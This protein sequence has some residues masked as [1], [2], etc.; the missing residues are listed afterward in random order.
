MTKWRKWRCG[1]ALAGLAL[2][3]QLATT[4]PAWPA[5]Q[6]VKIG[7][8]LSLSGPGADIGQNMLR[9][10]DLYMKLHMQDLP[11]G[12]SLQIIKRD[13]GSNAATTKRLAQELI[14]RDHVQMLAGITLSPEAFTLAP[15]ATEAKIPV[16]LMNA[17]TGS[18]T[19]SSPYIVRFSHSN[20]QMAYI[21]GI[22]A[23]TH[24][25]KNAY[26]LVA[27]Y[28]AGLDNEAAFRRGFTDN[29]GKIV[30]SD[31]APLTTN[32][33]LPYMDRIKA[34]APQSLFVFTLAGP[35]TI[36]TMKAFA[37][38]GLQRAGVQLLGTGDEVPDDELPEIGPA[39]LGMIDASVYAATDQRS[40][41]KQFVLAW[42]HEYGAQSV[43]DFG[44][45]GAWNGM[46]AIFGVVKQLGTKVTGD[47][48][49]A[50][51]KDFRNPDGPQG[52]LSVDPETRD[53]VQ[54]VYISK[55]DKVGDHY[56]NV[57]LDTVPDVKDPWKILNPAK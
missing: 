24:D 2:A 9:G 16:V 51:L 31:H 41:N 35:A 45:V 36:A 37:D 7:L 21:L 38:A 39:A 32:D 57:R 23:A 53:I 42:K 26:T 25:I 20:W 43:P 50:I 19:R 44:A 47:A 12:I 6:T 27:D 30:G 52:P 13:D 56:E 18:I 8:I 11:P 54:N 14:I 5:D 28:A 17:T 49:L 48:A 33:Y 46:A 4:R 29:G 40:Q 34:A 10:V 15:V 55:V 3:A 1:L 22:W